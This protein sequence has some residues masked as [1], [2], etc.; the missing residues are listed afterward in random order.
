MSEAAG[1]ASLCRMGARSGRF[2][3]QVE[4]KLVE[5]ELGLRAGVFGANHGPP[6]PGAIWLQVR[7][8]NVWAVPPLCGQ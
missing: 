4:E 5:D 3:A 1:M 8:A 2:G 6:L 7:E